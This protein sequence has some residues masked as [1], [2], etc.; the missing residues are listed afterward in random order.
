MSGQPSALL[1]EC[2]CTNKKSTRKTEFPSY[3]CKVKP[4]SRGGS[5]TLCLPYE[6]NYLELKMSIIFWRMLSNTRRCFS[7]AVESAVERDRSLSYF[8]RSMFT[9]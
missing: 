3:R 8:E 2:V 9:A 1:P 6:N 5:Y 4:F 7:N